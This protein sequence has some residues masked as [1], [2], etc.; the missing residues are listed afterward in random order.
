MLCLA[1]ISLGKISSEVLRSKE[2]RTNV[3]SRCKSYCKIKSPGNKKKIY[4]RFDY[5]T[6]YDET[7]NKISLKE[8]TQQILKENIR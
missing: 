2:L 1:V 5:E 3:I 6:A 4:Y 8:F 7:V